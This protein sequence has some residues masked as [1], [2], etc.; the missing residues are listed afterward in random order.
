MSD[1]IKT[2]NLDF[3]TLDFYK[4]Y[5]VSVVN[6][7]A[8][9]S[10]SQLMVIVEICNDFFEGKRY[11]Y[12]SERKN[13]YNVNPTIYLKLEEIKKNLMGI[14]IVSNK[15]SSIN[16]A[17]FEKTFSKVDFKTFLELDQAVEW[18]EEIIKKK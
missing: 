1:S 18:A 4:N 8:V 12:I 14:A 11:V 5:V 15:V 9:F 10:I 6:E 7:D 3:T 2:V 17:E 16:M 13:N